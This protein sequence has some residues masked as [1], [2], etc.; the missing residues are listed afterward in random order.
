VLGEM[1]FMGRK[2]WEEIEEIRKLGGFVSERKL[3]EFFI[4]LDIVW[5]FKI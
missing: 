5:V 2:L 1:E 4:Y 3:T